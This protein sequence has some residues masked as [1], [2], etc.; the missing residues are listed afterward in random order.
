MDEST[1]ENNVKIEEIEEESAEKEKEVE[2]EIFEEINEEVIKKEDIKESF[3]WIFF[4]YSGTLVD[5]VVPLSRSYSRFLGR[6]FPVEQVKKLYKDYPKSNKLGIMIKYKINPIK[7][8]FGG[9]KKFDEIRKEEF[10]DGVRAFPGI[11]D[12]LA[13]LHKMSQVKIAIVTH[14]TEL[15][16]EEEREKIMQKFGI[17]NVF[18]TVICD[19]WNKEES[20]ANFL[21]ENEVSYGLFIGDTQYDLDIGKKNHF[22]TVGVTWGFS[23]REELEADYTI[24][25]PRELL[26]III[27]LLRKAEQEKL[28][29]DPI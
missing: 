21:L 1:I 5:T 11:P 15:E 2:E 17:P 4:D 29:G 10:W 23:T 12:V 20:F 19:Y 9:K 28:H 14:E 13:R 27:T 6:E 3:P 7:F 25:D 26:Q 16:D 18:D 24:G 22:N 8:I